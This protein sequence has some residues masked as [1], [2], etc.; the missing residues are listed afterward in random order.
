M[1][2]AT[3]G[4]TVRI[5]YTGRLDDGTVFDSSEGRDPLEFVLGAGQ[6]I[7]GFD[8]AVTG[9]ETGEEKTVTIP[10]GE[11]Y[12]PR[13]DDLVINLGRAEIPEGLDPKVG[14]HLQMATKEGQTFQ[15][16]VAEATDTNVILDANHPLAGKDLIFDI[17]L[18]QA[19]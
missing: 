9:M 10:A 13:R 1:A 18:V 17:H 6:V 15:V 4:N 14:Q 7:P 11:A 16:T 12:G 5:H 19:T 8:Q 3:D 2:V